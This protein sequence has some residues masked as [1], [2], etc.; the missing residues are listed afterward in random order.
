MHA[1]DAC[2]GVTPQQ[3][4]GKPGKALFIEGLR[5]LG[6]PTTASLMIGDNPATDAIGASGS[7][8]RRCWSVCIRMRMSPRSRHCSRRNTHLTRDALA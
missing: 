4:V 6:A 5:R 2:S 7:A 1:V 8:C 3:I